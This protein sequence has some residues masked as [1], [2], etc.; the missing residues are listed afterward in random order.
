M[1]CLHAGHVEYESHQ[2]EQQL[3]SGGSRLP[4][5]VVSSQTVETGHGRSKHGWSQE[6]EIPNVKEHEH[7]DFAVDFKFKFIYIWILRI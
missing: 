6:A 7:W 4:T 1:Q 3:D 5:R 2:P